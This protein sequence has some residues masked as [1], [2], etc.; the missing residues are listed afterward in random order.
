[1]M[2][3]YDSDVIYSL[4][5]L[6]AR[7]MTV[8]GSDAHILFTL[9]CLIV[10]WAGKCGSGWLPPSSMSSLHVTSWGLSLADAYYPG[11]W[12]AERVTGADVSM[13]RDSP[14]ILTRL[15]TGPHW[16]HPQWFRWEESS[17]HRNGKLNFPRMISQSWKHDRKLS[18]LIFLRPA[19]ERK[20]QVTL[21]YIRKIANALKVRAP[22]FGSIK[23]LLLELVTEFAKHCKQWKDTEPLTDSFT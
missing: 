3:P 10:S 5:D 19:L 22:Y 13:W 17:K 2:S 4:R 20:Y 18:V 9:P 1:M 7:R 8:A 12:L 15:E 11:L 14:E 6:T 23:L 21:S 16:G